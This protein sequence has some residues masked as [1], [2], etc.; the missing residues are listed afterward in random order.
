M[1]SRIVLLGSRDINDVSDGVSVYVN[2]VFSAIEFNKYEI[3]S[4]IL[5]NKNSFRLRNNINE[6]IIRINSFDPFAKL[7]YCLKLLPKLREIS[8]KDFIILNGLSVIWILPILKLIYPKSKIIIVHHSAEFNNNSLSLS[9][10]IIAKLALKISYLSNHHISVSNY[11]QNLIPRSVTI[12]N[13]AKKMTQS[14][15]SLNLSSDLLY[16]GRLV[17][18]KGIIDLAK[19]LKKINSKISL[20]CI[21]PKLNKQMQKRLIKI[22]PNITFITELCR[23]DVL[24]YIYGSK[25]VI[26]PSFNE[27]FSLVTQEALNLGKIPLQ[28]DIEAL[29]EFECPEYSYFNDNNFE[30]VLL[31]ALGNLIK[32]K[33]NDSYK[34][35]ISDVADQWIVFLKNI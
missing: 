28:R 33:S 11:L 26:I 27:G 2:E 16:V 4:I 5:G 6:V 8:N 19:K 12:R 20:T 23:K 24:G 22:Y 15:Y 34:R 29:R 31:N 13:G 1:R 14:N 17:K 7:E 32:F 25:L 18:E 21:C 3:Y 30:Q 9:K 35:Y 10:R